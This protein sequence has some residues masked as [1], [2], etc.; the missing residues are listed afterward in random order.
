[1]DSLIIRFG[2]ISINKQ[3]LNN[4]EEQSK[5][6]LAQLKTKE[7]EVAKSLSDKYGKGTLDIESGEFTPED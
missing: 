3:A 7:A 6:L 1:M 2:Q 4:Q 5:S